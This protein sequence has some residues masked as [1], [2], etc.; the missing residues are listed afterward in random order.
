MISSS[1]ECTCLKVHLCQNSSLHFEIAFGGV[2]ASSHLLHMRTE[3]VRTEIRASFTSVCIHS[4]TRACVIQRRRSICLRTWRGNYNKSRENVDT[5]KW[6][7]DRLICLLIIATILW[8]C[9]KPSFTIID[10]NTNGLGINS[11]LANLPRNLN[12]MHL[13]HYL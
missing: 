4:V 5:R 3:K 8:L 12:N 1:F 13:D 11:E 9:G 10:F 6:M 7:I 2:H